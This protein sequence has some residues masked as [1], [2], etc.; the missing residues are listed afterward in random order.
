MA[1]RAKKLDLST[2]WLFSACSSKELRVLRGA[3][4]EV[5]VPPGTVLTAEK[6]R[7]R[8][9]FLIVEGTAS[10][11]HQGKRV[12][13]LGPDRYFGELS[14]LDRGTRTATVTSETEMS[15]LVL[16]QREFGGILEAVPTMTRKLLATTATRLRES[17]ER[18]Y[19]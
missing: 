19:H 15:L 4:E 8:E 1:T 6:S 2:I 17:D 5:T 3:L 16:G 7:G 18:A 14:L 10:V 13:T 11:V 12:A 9:F